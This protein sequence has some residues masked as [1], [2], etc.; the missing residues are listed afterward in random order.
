MDHYVSGKV[1]MTFSPGIEKVLT[2]TGSPVH[3]FAGVSFL[4]ADIDGPLD[5]LV[6]VAQ[7]LAFLSAACRVATDGLTYSRTKF[8]E[9]S[10]GL[11]EHLGD[12]I[13]HHFLVK[14]PTTPVGAGGPKSCWNEIIGSSV[15]VTGFPIANRSVD[16]VGL[17]APLE[18]LANFIG[19]PHATKYDGGFVIKGRRHAIIP[20]RRTS[21]CVQWHLVCKNVG[22]L[23]FDEIDERISQ[24]LS[25]HQLN[26]ADLMSTKAFLGWCFEAKYY[27][28]E[29][30]SAVA[31][32]LHLK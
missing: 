28:G 21:A 29:L 26:E 27:L 13:T 25:F 2:I 14:S 4:V 6:A 3:M 1:C 12:S 32:R 5:F 17:S 16:Y 18:L 22:K 19:A 24:R 15:I 30:I 11:L 7:Q 23:D 31:A 8:H 9:R 10:L 20:V